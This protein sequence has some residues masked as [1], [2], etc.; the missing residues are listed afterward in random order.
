MTLK[1]IEGLL[2]SASEAYYAGD[3]FLTDEQF[4]ALAASVNF[5]DVGSSVKGLKAKHTYRMYSLK[6]YYPGEGKPPLTEYTK[7]KITTPKLDGAAISLLYKEG[8]FVQALTRG[9]GFEGQV[10]TAK[11]ACS[12]LIP[13]EISYKKEIQITGEIVAPKDIAN[14]RNYAAGALGL[15]SIEEFLC[16]DLYFVAYGANMVDKP[17]FYRDTLAWLES[18]GFK[19]VADS[20]LCDKFPQD[21][22][23]TRIDSE[24]DFNE[25]GFTSKHPSGA[26]ATKSRNAEVRSILREVK[27]QTGRSGKVTPVALFDPVIID[28]ATISR[29]T[30]NNPGFIEALNLDLGDFVY[31]ERAGDIIPAVVRSEKPT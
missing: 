3:P 26:F 14:A 2:K 8:K 4:D 29:A 27:W 12:T 10:I 7:A 13:L 15:N 22:V 18:L 23:V 31:I 9:D 25:Y 17:N 21:G 30:L 1:H 28:G 11:L 24:K 19:T 16:R 5:S 6:K 20:D